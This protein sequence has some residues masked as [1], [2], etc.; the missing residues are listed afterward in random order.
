MKTQFLFA[1]AAALTAAVCFSPAGAAAPI[2]PA[3]QQSD[4]SAPLNLEAL[5]SQATWVRQLAAHLVRDPDQAEDL[6]QETWRR[7]LERPPTGEIPEQGLRAWFARVMRNLVTDRQVESDL[8]SW[9]ERHASRSEA[10]S[11]EEL[12]DRVV[13]QRELAEAVLSLEQPYQ[14]AITLRYLEGLTPSEI[15]RRQNVSDAA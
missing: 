8:R 1:C 9:H 10:W 12:H 2:Q 13:L 6:V 3:D 5:L 11:Q 15:A 4:S 7:A 14:S